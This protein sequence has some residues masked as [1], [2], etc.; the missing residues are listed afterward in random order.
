MN[1]RGSLDWDDGVL[2]SRALPERV[3][4]VRCCDVQ[5]TVEEGSLELAMGVGKR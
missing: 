3:K 2:R 5:G 4:Y 1:E